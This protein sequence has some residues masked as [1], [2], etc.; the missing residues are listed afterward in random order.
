[1]CCRTTFAAE[2]HAKSISHRVDIPKHSAW[3]RLPFLGIH[4]KGKFHLFRFKLSVMKTPRLAVQLLMSR[5]EQFLA[6]VFA[7]LRELNSAR[8]AAGADQQRQFASAWAR[9]LFGLI[10]VQHCVR[11]NQS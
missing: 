6:R 7:A 5:G 3:L 10:C 8:D 2:G 1:M 11:Y 4:P 9:K